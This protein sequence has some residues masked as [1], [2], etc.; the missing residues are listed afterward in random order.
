MDLRV[1]LP[2]V[3]W[4]VLATVTATAAQPDPVAAGAV[5]QSAKVVQSVKKAPAN[6]GPRSLVRRCYGGLEDGKVI[7]REGQ[8]VDNA[9][10]TTLNGCQVDGGAAARAPQSPTISA[11]RLIV[12]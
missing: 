6:Q 5:A 1:A 10:E 11:G 12:G 2:A 8:V 7:V 4:V 3:F 9:V